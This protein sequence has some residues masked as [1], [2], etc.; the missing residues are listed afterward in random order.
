MN[1]DHLETAKAVLAKA[2]LGDQ[3]FARPD[4]GIL[5]FWAE[6][7]GGIDREAALRAVTAHY[8][9]DHR[10]L[11]PSDI[12]KRVRAEQPHSTGPILTEIPLGYVPDADP[13]DVPAYLA[14]LRDKRF[15]KAPDVEPDPERARRLIAD[16]IAARAAAANRTESEAS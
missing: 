6:A 15:V 3:T 4:P 11:M 9:E 10:R 13:D 5:A 7:L 16:T 1:R 2:S 14:A 8:T 12:V